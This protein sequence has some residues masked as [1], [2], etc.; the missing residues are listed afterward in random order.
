MYIVAFQLLFCTWES[1]FLVDL[2]RGSLYS[3]LEDFLPMH[4]ETG[5]EAYPRYLFIVLV[6]FLFI[7]YIFSRSTSVTEKIS[8][9]KHETVLYIEDQVT[10]VIKTFERPGC[11]QRIVSSIRKLYPSIK[12]C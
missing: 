9:V 1:T 2:N 4:L 6:T 7:T 3:I 8:T 11:V 10:I 5:K 12:V